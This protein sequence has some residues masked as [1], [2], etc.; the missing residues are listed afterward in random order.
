MPDTP[1]RVQAFDKGPPV[2]SVI[3]CFF[4]VMPFVFQPLEVCL[5]TPFARCSL[6][7]LFSSSLEGSMSKLVWF[8][9]CMSDPYSSIPPLKKTRKLTKKTHT[10][11]PKLVSNITHLF[12]FVSRHPDGRTD[13]KLLSINCNCSPDD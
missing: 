1:P 11:I 4:C 10:V 12:A 7:V 3:C 6:A 13:R 9:Q 8:L 2:F 5:K